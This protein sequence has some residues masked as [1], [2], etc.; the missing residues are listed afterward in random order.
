MSARRPAKGLEVLQPLR[1]AA[2]AVG[3]AVLGL[4]LGA[5]AGCEA[6][7]LERMRAPASETE[8]FCAAVAAAMPYAAV[9][10]A[11]APR[12]PREFARGRAQMLAGPE[13]ELALRLC[14]TCRES[15]GAA[16]REV[17]RGRPASVARGAA[18]LV[19]ARRV[20]L[21]AMPEAFE[22]WSARV[23]AGVSRA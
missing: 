2:A 11:G 13:T 19:A 4:D 5:V 16:M 17:R 12:S 21:E 8:L 9:L 22:A 18:D 20:L 6:R 1:D 15:I 7:A 14:E 3:A 23:R 10:Q